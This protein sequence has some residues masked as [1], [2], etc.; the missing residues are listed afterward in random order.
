MNNFKMLLKVFRVHHWIKNLLLFIPLITSHKFY[1][2]ELIMTLCVAFISFSFCAS[3]IYIFNDILDIENDRAHPNKK[4]RPFA[5]SDI[6]IKSGIILALISL[7]ISF[8]LAL[9]LNKLFI[10][11]LSSYLAL[12]LLYSSKV[13]NST[14]IKLLFI[15]VTFSLILNSFSSHSKADLYSFDF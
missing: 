8:V 5:S 14:H 3:S 15:F 2:L 4:N 10:I 11:F 13:I 7:L 6:S 9:S 12:S 1:N